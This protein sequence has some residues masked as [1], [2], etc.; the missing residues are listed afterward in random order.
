MK[1]ICLLS[2][3]LD[4]ILAARLIKEQGIEIIGLKFKIPFFTRKKAKLDNLNIEVKEVDIS[5]DF[6]NI[7]YL[8]YLP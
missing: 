3:G 8:L 7:V 1:A 4:S 2:G 6:L 5:S